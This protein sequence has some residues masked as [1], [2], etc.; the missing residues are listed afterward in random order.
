M[1]D[2]N[3]GSSVSA[4]ILQ[5]KPGAEGTCARIV[6]VVARSDAENIHMK[7]GGGVFQWG[8]GYSLG[9]RVNK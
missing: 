5:P 1:G 8:I 2:R 7:I 9:D 3:D 4:W 6:A